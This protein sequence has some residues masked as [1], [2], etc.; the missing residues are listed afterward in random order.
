MLTPGFLPADSP[1]L[2]PVEGVLAQVERNVAKQMVESREEM[3]SL[4]LGALR[5]I[6]KMPDL[7]RPCFGQPELQCIAQ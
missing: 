3:K 1:H 5:C 2:N 6:Q 4:A 7:V